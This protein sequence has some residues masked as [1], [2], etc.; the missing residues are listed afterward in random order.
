LQG[1]RFSSPLS[2]R[3]LVSI[4]NKMVLSKLKEIQ[5]AIM[6]HSEEEPENVTMFQGVFSP[7]RPLITPITDPL[8]FEWYVPP[9]HQHWQR[10]RKALPALSAIGIDNIWLP[11]GCKGGSPKSNGY[12]IYDLYD[13]GEFEQ[14]GG[15]TTK[16]GT[17]EELA[18]L[19]A[20][21]EANGVGLHWDA[22]LNH[23]AAADHTETCQAVRVDPIGMVACSCWMM[24]RTDEV[25]Q[26][27]RSGR[28]S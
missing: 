9:D 1:K 12:D 13:L 19:C 15:R 25:R 17:R 14:K 18:E 6:P 28:A 20:A 16:W 7:F 27:K 22:V 5:S 24:R 3:A 23:K 8:Q 10:L 11:P 4:I 26:A 21:A 2:L